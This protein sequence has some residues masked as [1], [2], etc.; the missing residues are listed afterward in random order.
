MQNTG[1]TTWTVWGAAPPPYG[2]GYRLGDPANLVGPP[3][4]TNPDW[5]F[6]RVS[7]GAPVAPSDSTTFS[8]DITAPL[9]P[10]TYTFPAMQMADEGIAFFGETSDPVSVVVGP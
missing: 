2:T 6:G 3:A 1:N 5:G 7:V 4:F 9:T 10:G 8:V